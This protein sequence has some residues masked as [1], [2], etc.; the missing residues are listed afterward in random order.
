MIRPCQ[1]D[2]SLD[3]P[4][5]VEIVAE[6]VKVGSDLEI[7][8]RLGPVHIGFEFAKSLIVLAGN[9]IADERSWRSGKRTH[10]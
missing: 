9:K 4:G 7:V 5:G 1:R 2:G 8:K 3:A 10:V 6:G